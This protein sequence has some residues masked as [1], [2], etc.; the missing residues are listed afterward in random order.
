VIR[1]DPNAPAVDMLSAIVILGGAALIVAFAIYVAQRLERR[2][3]DAVASITNERLAGPDELEDIAI[4]A[5]TGTTAA[6]RGR[7][8]DPETSLLVIDDEHTTTVGVAPWCPPPARDLS[9]AVGH[10]QAAP[11][12][13][14]QPESDA[15]LR[16][17]RVG[18]RLDALAAELD[19]EPCAVVE[20]LARRV[21]GATEPVADTRARRFGQPWTDA[22]LRI[23]HSASVAGLGVADIARQLGRDQ[24]SSVFRLLESAAR[25]RSGV[26]TPR[27]A[28]RA[29][30][31]D[32]PGTPVPQRRGPLREAVLHG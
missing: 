22:E 18:F 31:R 29:T 8:A 5:G 25:A 1:V 17:F 30:V 27:P 28:A 6:L 32:V 2:S 21:F 3:A 26:N 20:E 7:C 9:D 11:H 24:L 14:S 4:G 19:V 16:R 10:R 12:A 15:L 13:W 23:L